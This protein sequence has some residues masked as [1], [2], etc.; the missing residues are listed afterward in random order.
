MLILLFANEAIRHGR[1]DSAARSRALSCA[2][3]GTMLSER[4]I[5]IGP[6]AYTGS[7]HAKQRNFREDACSALR[8]V[9]VD[10]Y[11]Q[12]HPLADDA[13]KITWST[14]TTI[15]LPLRRD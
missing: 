7:T 4:E 13:A 8:Q 6:P 14:R 10:R 3:A 9:P 5:K 11:E 1:P 2:A 12:S 15:T